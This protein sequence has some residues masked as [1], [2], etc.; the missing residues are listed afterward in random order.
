M[1]I[2]QGTGGQEQAFEIHDSVSENADRRS[3]SGLPSVD[4]QVIFGFHS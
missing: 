2:G 4:E 1:Q 3:P